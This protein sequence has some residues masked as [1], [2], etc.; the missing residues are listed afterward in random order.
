MTTTRITGVLLSLLPVLLGRL[1]LF[2]ALVGGAWLIGIELDGMARLGLLLIAVVVITLDAVLTPPQAL[3]A[4]AARAA[5][6]AEDA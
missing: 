6:R 4:V 3:A 5:Y 2:A 1:R